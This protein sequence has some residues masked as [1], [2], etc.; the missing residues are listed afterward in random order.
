MK[1]C[2]QPV[3]LVSAKPLRGRPGYT[4]GGSRAIALTV[5]TSSLVRQL[6]PSPPL[7]SK[8]AGSKPQLSGSA[9]SP[10]GASHC[11]MTVRSISD[12]LEGKTQAQ[13]VRKPCCV[14]QGTQ[15]G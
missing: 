14:G 10:L 15:D 2:V 7:H 13:G 12:R 4:A 8:D 3:G 6:G 5:S 9:N 11:L 1:N